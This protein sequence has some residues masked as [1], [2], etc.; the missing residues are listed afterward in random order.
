MNRREFLKTMTYAGLSIPLIGCLN[1]CGS[2]RSIYPGGEKYTYSYVPTV[3]I[4]GSWLQMGRQYGHF[5]SDDIRAVYNLVAPYKDE[6]NKGFGKNNASLREELYQS[7]TDEFKTFLQGVSETSGLTLE[8]LKVANSLEISLMFG[9]SIYLNRCSALSTWGEYSNA[10][11]VV[12]GRNYDY[13]PEFLPLNDHIVVTV[14]HPDNGDIPFAICTWAG[15]IY[16]STA[17]NRK[18]IFAEEN[19]CSPHD[20]DSAGFNITDGHLNMKTWVRDD[21]LLLSMMGKAG[22][23]DEADKWMKAN[24]PVY[25]HNIGVADKN[26]ARCYQWNVSARVPHAPYVRQATGLMA[27]TNHYFVIPEG[28]SLAAYV[29]QG[30]DGSTIPGGSVPRLENLLQL[31]NQ[32]KGAID[33][34]RMC[35]I[36]DRKFEN[37][38]ATVDGTLYQIVCE[39][40]SFTFKLKTKGRPDSWV[41]I[42][43]AKL[44]FKEDFK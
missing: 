23:M 10:G 43:L 4:S 39:P 22:T 24:F 34:T 29:E 9:S 2:S 16:A 25:P 38:G 21:I 13:S 40:E 20:K 26:E 37:G 28:W 44:L 1:S 30:S 3:V 12:Y 17:I 19:D 27:Q 36:M 33:V 32:H 41:D 31:A 11:R 18:G 15:C 5:L 14:F 7:Y 6:Y 42:P 35:E 8:E